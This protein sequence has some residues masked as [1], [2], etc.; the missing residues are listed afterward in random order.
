[1][2][3]GEKIGEN[4][5]PGFPVQG[6]ALCFAS[7]DFSTHFECAWLSR[8][9]SDAG[10][11]PSVAD[12]FLFK[13]ESSLKS[14]PMQGLVERCFRGV[15]VQRSGRHKAAQLVVVANRETVPDNLVPQKEID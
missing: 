5:F 12:V 13:P 4:R 15:Q 11:G 10:A 8:S 14:L 7:G 6:G 2:Q 1:M 3:L 9:L